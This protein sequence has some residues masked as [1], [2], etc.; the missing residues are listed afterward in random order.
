MNTANILTKQTVALNLKGTTKEAVITEL[1]GVLG[2]AGQIK[3]RDAALRV[4]LDREKK[5]S[6]G[7]QNGIAIPHG[8]TDTVENLVAA[9]GIKKDG[10]PFESLDGQPA[11]IIVATLSPTNKPGP[12]IQFLAE[13]SKALGDPAVREH[14][15]AATT[16]EAVLG[17][18]CRE[19]TALPAA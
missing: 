8:K 6:T 18:I 16:E 4:V 13:I 1:I 17:A 19:K 12:H 14:L 5:M 2:D 9:I 11:Q 10:V 15:L 7:L 3:D